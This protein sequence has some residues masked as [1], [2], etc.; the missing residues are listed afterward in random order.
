M[1]RLPI[2]KARLSRLAGRTSPATWNSSIATRGS[3]SSRRTWRHFSLASGRRSWRVARPVPDGAAG[4]AA[5][6]AARHPARPPRGCAVS[7]PRRSASTTSALIRGAGAGGRKKD[8]GGA[9]ALRAALKALQE[10][11]SVACRLGSAA[12]TGAQ[13]APAWHRDAGAHVRPAD[14]S[15]GHG[16]EPLPRLQDLEPH[17]A[18][19]ALRHAGGR[20]R[21]AGLGAARCRR[22]RRSRPR[23]WRSRRISIA[24]TA[25]AYR[26]RRRRHRDA[27]DTAD[28]CRR[29]KS[30]S[31]PRPACGLK[32]YR[33]A[34]RI[35]AAGRAAAARDAR[36]AAAGR[37][38]AR[39][40]RAARRRRASRGRRAG[41]SGCMPPASASST[42]CCR[43]PTRCAQ[44]RP[45]SRFLFTTGTVTSARIAAQRLAPRRH[46][47]VRAARHAARSWRRF[48]DHWRPDLAIFTESE[49]W[50]NMVLEVADRGDSAGARQCPHVGPLVRAL[51]QDASHGAPAVLALRCRAGA[52][53]GA[54]AAVSRRSAHRACW[55]SA[56]SRSMRRRRRSTRRS[57]RDCARR[58]AAARSGRGQHARGRGAG[59]RRGAPAD[60]R[61]AGPRLLHDHCAAPS[62]ARHAIAEMLKAQGLTV[63]QRS[64]GDAAG[65]RHRHLHRRHDR[66]AR[67][68]LCAGA[69]RLH[70]RL[71]GGARR[72]EPDRGHPARRAS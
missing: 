31:Q 55:P 42:P 59:H 66:R 2:D 30:R 36:A 12:G 52:E 14:H 22:R 35:A 21:R 23:G 26:A 34:T 53:R 43:W 49:I 60:R 63:A 61:A 25:R 68:A 27:G 17:D 8:R 40:Q 4:Q 3:S 62:R 72:P 70:R 11:I 46:P 6:R 37:M 47:P 65:A 9:Y 16:V 18:Q 28:S 5:R 38:R 24:A 19:P 39:R 56:T 69:D 45:T 29:A 33:A 44:A 7:S 50:P 57:W 20:V 67:H 32:T 54:G 71:A 10:G 64:L 1:A 48:L 15:D 41:S 51:E 13:S 58:S